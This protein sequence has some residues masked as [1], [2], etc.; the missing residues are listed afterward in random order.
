MKEEIAHQGLRKNLMGDGDLAER[1]SS[2]LHVTARTPPCFMLHCSDDST[3]VV[4]NSLR[5]YQALV[6][7]KVPAACMIFENG[8]H[9]QSAFVNNPSWESAF[10]E[11]LAKR[12]CIK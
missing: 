9:G 8:G 4:E 7:N 1:Y 12:G 6:A 5:F 3:V 11:W 2:E 10:N